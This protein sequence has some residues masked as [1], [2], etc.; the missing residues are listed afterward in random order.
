MLGITFNQVTYIPN[1][2]TYFFAFIIICGWSVFNHY[3]S[4]KLKFRVERDKKLEGYNQSVSDLKNQLGNIT[5][6]LAPIQQ[7]CS[8]TV[9]EDITPRIERLKRMLDELENQ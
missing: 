8:E 5:E 9:G 2:R 3:I 6:E 4:T 1:K 7:W